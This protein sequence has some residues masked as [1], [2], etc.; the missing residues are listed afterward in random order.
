MGLWYNTIQHT[1]QH[2]LLKASHGM[3]PFLKFDWFTGLVGVHISENSQ[4]AQIQNSLGVSYIKK[5]N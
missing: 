3:I 4:R 1:V 2:Q 5:S